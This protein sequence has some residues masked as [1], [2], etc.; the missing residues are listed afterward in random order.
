VLD[1]DRRSAWLTFAVDGAGPTGVEVAGQIAEL[2]RDTLRRDFD[3]IDPRTTYA[4]S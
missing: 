4:S 3:R 1:R 2:A